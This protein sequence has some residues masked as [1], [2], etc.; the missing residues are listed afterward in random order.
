MRPKKRDPKRRSV[1]FPLDVEDDWPPVGIECLPFEEVERG[2]KLLAPPLFVKKFSVGDVIKVR[3]RLG[4]VSSWK[5]TM[6]S[7]HSTIWLLRLKR[8]ATREIKSILEHLHELGCKSSSAPQLGAYAIDVPPET[9][10]RRVDAVLAA[11]DR[12]RVAIA[13]P[14]FRHRDE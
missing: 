7:G 3:E 12:D 4:R 6:R 1:N 14:S 2:L 13:Y 8:G 9:P 5:Q 11:L 10:I